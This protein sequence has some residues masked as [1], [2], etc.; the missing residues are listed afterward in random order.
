MWHLEVSFQVF[1]KVFLFMISVFF[2][3]ETNVVFEPQKGIQKILC[4]D[5]YEATSQAELEQDESAN[6]VSSGFISPGL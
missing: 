3:W 2:L 6:K 5:S 4:F 1:V